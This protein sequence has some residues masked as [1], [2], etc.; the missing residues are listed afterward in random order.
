MD[1]T[2]L[3]WFV[4]SVVNNP[5]KIL[6]S[7]IIT[8]MLFASGGQYLQFT[9]DFRQFFSEDNPQLIA[10]DEMEDTY[11]KADNVIFVIAPD[12]GNV[13]TA[14]TLAIVEELTEKAW[15]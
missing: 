3:E 14:E 10:F 6:L 2:K 13:F 7:S 1:N 11:T 12:D 8:V 15:Q 9:N 5:W 4:D